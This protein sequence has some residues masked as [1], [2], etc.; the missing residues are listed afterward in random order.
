MSK[1][2][3]NKAIF[4]TVRTGSTRLPQKALIKIQD[5]ATIEHLIHRVRRSEKTDKIIVCTTMLEEDNIICELAEKNGVDF[6]RGSTE[7]KLDRWLQAAVKFDVDFF[8]TADGDDLFCE[9]ELI[10]LAF[11][12]YEKNKS[13]F[14]EADGL[15][16]GAFTYGIS[17]GALSRACELKKTNDTEL[18][19]LFFKEEG[20]CEAEKL[21]NV[22]DI[23][24]RPEIRMTLDYE[25]DFNFFKNVIDHFHD[26]KQDLSLRK[27]IN[28]L[29]EHPEVIE[30]NQY[31]H[32]DFINN[33]RKRA[34]LILDEA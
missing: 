30:I 10:D 33:Q 16:C 15:A 25:E 7:D 27:I 26:I 11:E 2:S 4:I 31:R 24:K 20:V 6:F 29:N 28:Y 9:P 19:W 14:I 22:P 12:Q 1:N 13:D 3:M 8:V 34:T 5:K 17:R 21:E 18:S 23:F 32:E